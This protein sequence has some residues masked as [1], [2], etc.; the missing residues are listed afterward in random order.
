MNKKD[1]NQMDRVHTRATEIVRCLEK[2]KGIAAGLVQS[3]KL[4]GRERHI[5]QMWGRAAG[6]GERSRSK[7]PW[8]AMAAKATR[9]VGENNDRRRS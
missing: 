2:S 6:R 3:K 8:T 7:K 4:D 5:L 9:R 1:A